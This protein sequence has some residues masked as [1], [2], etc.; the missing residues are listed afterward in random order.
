MDTQSADCAIETFEPPKS[1]M[2]R[3]PTPQKRG[4]T[5]LLQGLNTGLRALGGGGPEIESDSSDGEEFVGDGAHK[6]WPFKFE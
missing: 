4:I 3:P 1:T 6:W 5:R 2:E